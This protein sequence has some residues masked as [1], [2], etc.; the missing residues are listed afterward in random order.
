MILEIL[1]T[2]IS[3]ILLIW[4]ILRRKPTKLGIRLDI[5][6]AKKP[7]PERLRVLNEAQK[8]WLKKNNLEGVKVDKKGVFTFDKSNN[9]DI[10][11][12]RK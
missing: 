5:V 1:I 10:K 3:L 11:N 2:F 6:R 7:S 9:V 4:A 8:T 12:R